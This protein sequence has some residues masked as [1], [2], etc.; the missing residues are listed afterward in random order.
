MLHIKNEKSLDHKKFF[1]LR[2]DPNEI[3]ILTEAQI[4]ANYF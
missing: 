1:M 2:L 3:G 4:S